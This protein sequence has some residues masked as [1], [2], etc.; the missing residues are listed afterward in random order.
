MV[1]QKLHENLTPGAPVVP[2]FVLEQEDGPTVRPR[3][4]DCPIRGPII[5]A[6]KQ[7]ANA[8]HAH[9]LLA[10][11]HSFAGGWLAPV[12]NPPCWMPLSRYG[13]PAAA[14]EAAG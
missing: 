3:S 12:W 5:A 1:L 9:V 4:D 10:P 2:Q 6:A 8:S 14:P 13:K 11:D 7:P